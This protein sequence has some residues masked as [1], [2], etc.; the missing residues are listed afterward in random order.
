MHAGHFNGTL[1][2]L[3]LDLE[4]LN[5]KPPFSTV[6]VK[7]KSFDVAISE[8]NARVLNRVAI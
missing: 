6:P 4:P 3:S 2:Q 8:K 5:L 7:S 1:C